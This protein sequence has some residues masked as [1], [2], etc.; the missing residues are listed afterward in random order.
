MVS[1]AAAAYCPILELS[2]GFHKFQA[3]W[4]WVLCLQWW[5]NFWHLH[6][7]KK[8]FPRCFSPHNICYH[9]AAICTA[10]PPWDEKS[11]FTAAVA[12][13]SHSLNQLLTAPSFQISGKSV[14]FLASFLSPGPLL[15]CAGCSCTLKFQRA[16]LYKK[17]SSK[18]KGKCFPGDYNKEIWC[19]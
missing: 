10:S 1:Y 8:Y 2:G 5:R 9:Q 6:W 13:S 12:T 7:L 14:Y 15:L 18:Y 17:H 3:S 4:P 19:F 11:S 16:S